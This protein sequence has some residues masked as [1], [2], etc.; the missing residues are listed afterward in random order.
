MSKHSEN[1]LCPICGK[2]NNCG[3]R[4]GLPHGSCWCDTIHVPQGL[5]DLVPEHFKMKACICK[6]CIDKYNADHGLD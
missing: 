3:S 4:R 2:D 1:I 5:K 6:D